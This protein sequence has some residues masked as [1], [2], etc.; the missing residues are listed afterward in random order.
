MHDATLMVKKLR[1]LTVDWTE[2]M[3][4]VSAFPQ[5]LKA[6]NSFLIIFNFYIYYAIIKANVLFT[7]YIY[8]NQYS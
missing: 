3:E 7:H 8:M 6:Y 5:P 1:S 2:C 4:G